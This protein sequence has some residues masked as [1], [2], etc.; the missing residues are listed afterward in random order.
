MISD[1]LIIALT[2]QNRSS[3]GHRPLLTGAKRSGLGL[4]EYQ[5]KVDRFRFRLFGKGAK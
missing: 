5:T 3:E 1:E 4:A 2:S